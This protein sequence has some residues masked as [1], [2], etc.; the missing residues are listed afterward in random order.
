[1]CEDRLAGLLA[2]GQLLDRT[3]GQRAQV[4]GRA[5]ERGER[6]TARLVGERDGEVAAGGERLD[7]RPLGAG[8]VLEAV[9]EYRAAVPGVKFARDLRRRVAALELAVPEA[10]PVELLAI[11]RVQLGE[12]TV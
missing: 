11:G 6:V 7:E 12:L 3:G 9:G 8:Q 4:L 2:R 5:R 1:M 10:E